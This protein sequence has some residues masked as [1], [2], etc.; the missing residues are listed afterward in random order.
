MKAILV[1]GNIKTKLLLNG[2]STLKKVTVVFINGGGN[3]FYCA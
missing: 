1:N 2:M 3:N